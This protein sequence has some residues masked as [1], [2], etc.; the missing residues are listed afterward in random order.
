MDISS[1]ETKMTV[2]INFQP[3]LTTRIFLGFVGSCVFTYFMIINWETVQNGSWIAWLLFFIVCLWIVAIMDGA[4]IYKCELDK[5]S[6]IATVTARV[7][8]LLWAPQKE[9]YPLSKL[10]S[11]F[12]VQEHN[13]NRWQIDNGLKMSLKVKGGGYLCFA[14]TATTENG[15]AISK[16]LE[17]PL[18]LKL[19]SETITII[20]WDAN[21]EATLTPA[22]CPSCG[23]PLPAIQSSMNNTTCEHCSMSFI[24]SRS[25][26]RNTGLMLE[27]VGD[28][29]DMFDG[30]PDH[31]S[32][33]AQG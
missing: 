27:H 4:K 20:P 2:E 26:K 23:A 31:K 19:E 8:A 33:A 25:R 30:T 28:V 10:A 1:N 15:E 32:Q 22:P 29:P 7:G 14:S 24:L 12:L 3:M 18:R 5:N 21:S 9:K 16:F 13:E 6:N 11:I 17:V